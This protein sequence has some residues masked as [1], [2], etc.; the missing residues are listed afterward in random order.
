MQTTRRIA[1]TPA[2]I[3]RVWGQLERGDADSSGSTLR[4]ALL[5]PA[6]IAVL[7]AITVALVALVNRFAPMI[8]NVN[9]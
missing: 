6:V 7:T 8:N 5:I 1:R 9:P 3:T 4:T 2:L